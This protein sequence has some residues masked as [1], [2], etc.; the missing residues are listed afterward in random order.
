MSEQS[1]YLSNS[2]TQGNRRN[3]LKLAAFTAG[4]TLLTAC[5]A[6]T[7]QVKVPVEATLA[8]NVAQATLTAAK[9]K[10]YFPSGDPNLPDAYTAP[11][12][13]VQ[14]VPT[15]P[16]RGGIVRVLSITYQPPLTPEGQNAFWQELNRRVNV[17]FR[18]LSAQ[19]SDGYAQKAG[20]LLASGDM[21]DLFLMIPASTPALYPALQQGAFAD[22]TPYLTSNAI[23]QFP[24]L[25][26]IPPIVWKS[27][28]VDGKLYGIPR[29]R[30]LVGNV[31]IFRYDWLKKLGLPLPKN[32]DDFYQTMLAFTRHNPSGN[33][34]TKTWGLG[35]LM[36]TFN[37]I[38]QMFRVG[39]NWVLQSNGNLL[40]S[41]A[42]DEYKAA[43]AYLKKLYTAGIFYPNA[44]TQNTT[45]AKNG[46]IAGQYAAYYDGIVGVWGERTGA[47]KLDPD[48]DVAFLVPF[49]ADGGK[50]LSWYGSGNFGFTGFPSDAA[51]DPARIMELLGIMNYF[52]A[53]QFSLEGD[54]IT[55][56]IDGWD[57]KKG[58]NGIKVLTAT[59]QK[60]L[61][62]IW[63]FG[64]GIP[65]WYFSS[66]PPFGPRMQE[67]VRQQYVMG[68]PDPT[69][70]LISKTSI[71]RGANLLQLRNDYILRIL[72]GT[73]AP[74]AGVDA[75]YKEWLNNGGAQIAKEYM[76]QIQK[77]G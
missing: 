54:F 74:S 23:Q 62:D 40:P 2:Q 18:L 38:Q 68:I 34:R 4:S 36:T 12:P 51:K 35:N 71:K 55:N 52:S 67:L 59:G 26:K 22:L 60:E 58:K 66:D 32:A 20:S 13:L 37:F 15:P 57:N 30:P 27:I 70:G 69:L 11:P 46:L 3:F 21:P 25:A 31:L 77:Q 33:S 44:L 63:G 24:N 6:A 65:V 43:I 16:G 7:P 41:F 53:S 17:D 1:N 9:G 73:D 47:K 42:T 39:N 28:T 8:P 61:Q 56:G 45:Q 29:T 72:K 75:L 10:T 19:G 14:T 50:P 64:N 5:G 48:A 49:A 76:E